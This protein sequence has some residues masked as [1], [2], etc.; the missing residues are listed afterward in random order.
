MAQA[1]IHLIRGSVSTVPSVVESSSM[2]EVWPGLAPPVVTVS[3]RIM[4]D[5]DE[6]QRFRRPG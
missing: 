2:A 6:N 4:P 3:L 1:A 5:V